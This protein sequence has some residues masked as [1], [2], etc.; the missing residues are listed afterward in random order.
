MRITGLW[1]AGICCLAVALS[2]GGVDAQAATLTVQA[3][4]VIY[5]AGTQSALAAHMEAP[6]RRR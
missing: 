5:A 3:T 4:D 2:V 1:G 6:F